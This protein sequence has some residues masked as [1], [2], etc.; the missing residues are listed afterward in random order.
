MDIKAMVEKAVDKI[1]SDPDLMN[2]FKDDPVKA[3]ESILGVDL[4]DDLL[5]KVAT[6]VKGKI[7]LD[8]T[9]D[10]VGKLKGLF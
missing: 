3:L 9:S 5:D 7:S 2:K 6:A 10:L 1:K 8:S 4:P